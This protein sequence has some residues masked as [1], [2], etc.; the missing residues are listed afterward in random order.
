VPEGTGGTTTSV[1]K[2]AKG[3]GRKD[4]QQAERGEDFVQQAF[5]GRPVNL[6]SKSLGETGA[7]RMWGR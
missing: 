3:N 2:R 7:R 6:G 1:L 4:R 5:G